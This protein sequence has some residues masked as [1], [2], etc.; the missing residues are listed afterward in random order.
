MDPIKEKERYEFRIFFHQKRLCKNKTMMFRWQNMF[1]RLNMDWS[2]RTML[3]KGKKRRKN[4]KEEEEEEKEEE[5]K[6]EKGKEKEKGNEKEL[7]QEKG[8]GKG[9]ENEK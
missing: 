2:D 5:K 6:E 9:N 8:K 7:E 4:E 3:W 1:L